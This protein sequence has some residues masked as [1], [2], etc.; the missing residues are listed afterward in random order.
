MSRCNSGSDRIVGMKER[1]MVSSFVEETVVFDPERGF[2]MFTGI[3]TNLGKVINKSESSLI[4][5]TEKELI[6]NLS[7][8]AS[9]A[10]DGICLTV[11]DKSKGSFSVDFMPETEKKTNIK[12]LQIG[13]LVNLELPATANSLLSGHIVQGHIDG[14]AKLETITQKG[15]SYVL[16]FSSPKALSK[17]IVEKGSIAVNGISLTAI[18]VGEGFFTVGIIP[19]TWNKTMLRQLKLGDYA[20]IEVDILAKYLETLIRR[21]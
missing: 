19:H 15:N 12:Y 16:K 20:N 6:N 3:I 2:F 18:D 11:I 5:K 10:V 8:G 7:K 9:I 1:I 14:V 13:S 4:V 21:T 17:Y